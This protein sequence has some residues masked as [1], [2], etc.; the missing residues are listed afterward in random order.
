M[1]MTTRKVKPET[2][3]R[4]NVPEVH[5]PALTPKGTATPPASFHM[6]ED[7]LFRDPFA[8]GFPSRR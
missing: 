8:D 1:G 7:D 4:R 2:T 5:T 3:E 6:G